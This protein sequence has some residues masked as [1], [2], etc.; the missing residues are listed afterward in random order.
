M[1][2]WDP[3]LSRYMAK[4]R[5]EPV[6]TLEEET[7]LLERWTVHR[8]QAAAERLARSHLRYVV[9]C[10][11]RYRRYRVPLRD[12]I[13]EGNF[14]L[15]YALTKFDPSRGCRLVTYASYWIRAYVLNCIINSW[16]MVGAGAGPLRSKWFFRLRRERA[17]LTTMFGEGEAA[18]QQLAERL[19]MEHGKVTQML[20]QLDARVVS[21]DSCVHEGSPRAWVEVLSTPQ[22]DQGSALEEQ[23]ARERACVAVRTALKALDPRERMVVECRLLA[24]RGDELTL[25]EVGRRL[26]VSRERARQLEARAKRKLRAAVLRQ[27]RGTDFVS[28]IAA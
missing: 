7:Q 15:A 16:N 3:V 27:T 25:A 10:G 5:R 2:N 24:D 14:G 21:L 28:E 1:Q 20:N 13:A 17:R 6:L 9:A 8:D 18:D 22:V 26:G 4:V 11:V 23:Q 12:L 19:G